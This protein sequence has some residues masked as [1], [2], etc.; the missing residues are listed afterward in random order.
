MQQF[1]QGAEHMWPQT[2]TARCLSLQGSCQFKEY[3][4]IHWS[5]AGTKRHPCLHAR[6]S[7][8]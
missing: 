4:G 7:G 5:S 8:T 1:E 6:R 3:V 2:A